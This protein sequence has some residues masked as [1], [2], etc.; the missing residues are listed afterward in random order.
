MLSDSVSKPKEDIAKDIRHG[1]YFNAKEAIEYGIAD[2]I[3]QSYSDP[4]V[5]P[6]R[7]LTTFGSVSCLFT[8]TLCTGVL[9]QYECDD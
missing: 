4:S 9:C 2:R 1:R 5:F 3:I 7:F 8:D 6:V